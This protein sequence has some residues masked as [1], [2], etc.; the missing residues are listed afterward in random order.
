[1][2]EML[3][4]ANTHIPLPRSVQAPSTVL[5]TYQLVYDLPSDARA[6]AW[7]RQV[8]QHS[9]GESGTCASCDILA[10]PG[11]FPRFRKE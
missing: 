3:L 1:M 8:A 9:S 11:L 2:G 5:G 10:I 7:R 4:T 6:R